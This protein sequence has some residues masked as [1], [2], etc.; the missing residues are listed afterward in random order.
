MSLLVCPC[1]QLVLYYVDTKVYNKDKSSSFITEFW[2]IWNNTNPISFC[3][4]AQDRSLFHTKG[5]P[6]TFEKDWW[7]E[8]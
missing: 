7:N 3:I 5:K 1:V 2:H 4:D 8:Y 6:F